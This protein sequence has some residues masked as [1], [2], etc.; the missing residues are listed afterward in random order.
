MLRKALPWL[1]PLAAA[2]ALLLFLT[3]TAD[4]PPAS[5]AVVV[6][7]TPEVAAPVV[8]ATEAPPPVLNRVVLDGT[9]STA[10]F[11]LADDSERTIGLNTLLQPGWM[12]TALDSG[13]ATFATPSGE[14]RIALSAPPVVEEKLVARTVLVPNAPAVAADGEAV[15]R[16]T[17]PEC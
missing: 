15:S 3:R 10:R 6:T 1:V 9:R 14:Q 7:A 11:R 13:S 16:C 12:L 5:G 4:A 8:P 17:D 2:A